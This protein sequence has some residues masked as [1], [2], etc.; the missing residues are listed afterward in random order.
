MSA[1]SQYRDY[2]PIDATID[3]RRV[4]RSACQERRRSD[5]P[6]PAGRRLFLHPR[7]ARR[8]VSAHR[9]TVEGEYEMLQHKSPENRRATEF[10]ASSWEA[11][12]KQVFALPRVDRPSL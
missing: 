11:Q 10:E 4:L 7:I 12:P 9:D 6:F 5:G 2:P 8:W 1:P 3:S